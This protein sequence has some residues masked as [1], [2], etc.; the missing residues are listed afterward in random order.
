MPDVGI[1]RRSCRTIL[2]LLLLLLAW[3]GPA[4]ADDREQRDLVDQSRMT[5][6]NFLADSSMTWF[7]DHI[8]DAKGLFIVPQYMKGAL[9]YGAAGGSGVLR[10]WGANTSGQLGDST[11]IDHPLPTVVSGLTNVTSVTAG[12][13]STCAIGDRGTA[14]Q[15]VFCWGRNDWGQVGDGT[16]TERHEPALVRF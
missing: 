15:Q 14:K 9:I 16:T 3:M 10:C 6:A 7:R 1:Q 8:Q 12:A 4:L 13:G 2:A 5:L 11:T